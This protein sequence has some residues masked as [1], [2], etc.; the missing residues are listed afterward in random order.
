MTKRS[1]IKGYRMPE[2]IAQMIEDLAR[3]ERQ[4]TGDMVTNTDIV[5]KAVRLYQKIRNE[6]RQS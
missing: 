6:T 4:E 5:K 2:E 3:S 1:V